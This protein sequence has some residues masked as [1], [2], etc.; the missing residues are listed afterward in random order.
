MQT[1]KQNTLGYRIKTNTGY[2]NFSGI[3]CNGE[4]DVLEVIFEN[5]ISVKCT[6]DH[7]IFVDWFESKPISK[8]KVGDS[9]LSSNGFLKIIE[10]NKCGREVVYDV[11]DVDGVNRF[12]ANDILVHNCQFIGKTGTL[13][14]S[15]SMGRLMEFTRNKTYSFVIDGDIRFYKDLNK[16]SKYLVAIDPAMGL[17]G[18]FAAIQVF[19][20]PEFEQ[21]AE[22]MGD[23]LNQNDQVEKLKT[24]IEWMYADLKT[25]GCRRPEIYWS[26]ENNSVGEGFICSMREKAFNNN[27]N[28]AQDYIKRGNLISENGNKRIGFTTSKKTKTVA[29]AQLKNLLE[30]NRMI[31]HSNE[32]VKQLSNFTLREV[33]YSASGKG[34]HD[35]LISASLVILYMYL[36]C[37]NSL[38][39]HVP[40]TND[41]PKMEIM[42]K[43]YE[44]PFL[45]FN[46]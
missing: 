31:I 5:D 21:V 12:Y 30:T 2:K 10:I 8:L 26:L 24:L 33:N 42:D 23:K 19:S 38:D 35:D 46:R 16:Y 18:D 22:W 32:Y 15:L 44:M 14:D 7:E 6:S 29:C 17:E 36:Q 39:L 13:V 20:F 45:F 27:L 43:K 1:I 11:L 34:E 4:Q 28:N 25:K 9:V 3:S 37:K 40:I 41:V